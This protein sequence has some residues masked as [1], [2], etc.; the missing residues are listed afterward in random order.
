[1][2]DLIQ[3]KEDSY[4]KPLILWGARQVG[5]TWLMKQFASNC[6]Q[7]SVYISFYNNRRIA[8]IFE[9]D[10]NISRI[11]QALEIELHVE[12]DPE[13]TILLFDEVQHAPRVVESLKYFQEEAP[14]YYVIAAGSLLGVA[15]HEDISFPVGKVDEL[16]LYPLSFQEYLMARSE[17]QLASFLT[18]WKNPE[19]NAFRDRYMDFLR[20]Y[21]VVGGMPE[22]VDRFCHQQDYQKAREMQLNILSQYEGDFGKHAS[23]SLLPRIRMA[24]NAIPAQLAKENKKYFFGQVKPGARMKD[25]ELALQWLKDAGLIYLVNKVE[26]PAMPLKSYIDIS[27]F[28]VFMID[29]GL[30]GALSEL[31]IDSV[32]LG[33]ELFVEFKGAFTEQYVLQQL[34][35]ATSYTPYYYAGEKSTYETDF[36]V[37]KGKDVLPIEVKA[38]ENLHSKSARFYYDKFHPAYVIRVS[39]A[40]AVDQ[41]WIRNIPLWAVQSI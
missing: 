1:M 33:N 36:L 23:P 30:L 27:A 19:I 9:A 17:D 39:M 41:T 26:K 24:W 11:I 29:I 37:Q 20:E 32:L 13:R 2:Q 16:W 31:D 25:F 18:D 34:V 5:K 35:S 12:I 10:Y 28:K 22:I 40:G 3:W 4:R 38:K 6:F 14:E 7:N 21:M 8:S 15:L